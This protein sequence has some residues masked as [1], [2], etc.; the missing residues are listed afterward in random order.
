MLPSD[1]N[2]ISYHLSFPIPYRTLFLV[3]AGILAWA[4]NLHFLHAFGIDVAGAMDLRG[5]I[6][7]S[8][9]VIPT[10]RTAAYSYST[11]FTR[12]NAVYQLFFSY[13]AFCFAS[14]TIYRFLTRGDPLLVD[15]YGYI[16]VITAL[17]ILLIIICPYNVFMKE[18]RERFTL[19]IKRCLFPP[20][21]GPIYFSDVIFADVGTSFARIFGDIWLSL[22]MLKP[23]NSILI[24]PSV[25]GWGAVVLPVIMS[26][27]F[28]LRFRQC[29]IEYNSTLN[30]SRK[31]LF[32]AIKYATSFPVI[33]LSA[34]QRTVD[35]DLIKEKGRILAGQK[36][37]G[38]HPLFRLWILATVVNSLYSFWWD[39]S[40][41]WG[42][43]L[44]QFD[45]PKKQDR[46]MPRVPIL[47]RITSQAPLSNRG[48]SDSL[49]SD[50]AIHAVE[51]QKHPYRQSCHGLRSILLYPRAIYPVLI[52]LN[53][54]FRMSWSVKLSTHVSST[55]DGT[56]AFFW[57]EV[58]EL[59]R[60]WLWVFIRVEW[61]S[62][63]KAIER[64]PNL[65]F[66]RASNDEN[67]FEMVPAAPDANSAI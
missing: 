56:V 3:G 46:Q 62:I 2:E 48:S 65:Q 9:G 16:P 37:H 17:T 55:R 58:A 13:S 30:D 12:Y 24:P 10:H 18:E 54:V 6:A 23:G 47:T 63:K 49:L 50:Q 66:D 57:L 36:W 20:P 59:V 31:P 7:S 42:L 61:E 45:P 35:S 38:E 60:R 33:F 21:N 4:T 8:N 14:W 22:C 27:P 39:V 11:T 25:E 1:D 51:I 5:D 41:D 28:F 52:F 44:L 53:L 15:S 43:E 64:E 67:D 19:A 34:A 26:L 29:I 40:Q 32:N